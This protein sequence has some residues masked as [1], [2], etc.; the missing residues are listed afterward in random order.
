[1]KAQIKWLL[2]TT[3]K[4]KFSH[5]F[6]QQC[7]CSHSFDSE[8]DVF[9]SMPQLLPGWTSYTFCE[10]VCEE[11]SFEFPTSN[12]WGTGQ[13]RGTRGCCPWEGREMGGGRQ[14]GENTGRLPET[15]VRWWMVEKA[16]GFRVHQ[17]VGRDKVG[18]ALEMV[19]EGH[20]IKE[21]SCQY[22][23]TGSNSNNVF[24]TYLSL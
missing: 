7:E 5:L 9:S 8:G 11:R 19:E 21:E 4:M 14:T 23:D 22:N 24:W 6:L 17:G 2:F 15:L 3:K 20:W 12:Q 10:G 18:D 16:L 1:M 13:N